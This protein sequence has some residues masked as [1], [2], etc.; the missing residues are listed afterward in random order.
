MLEGLQAADSEQWEAA[1]E[2]LCHQLKHSPP[3]SS[4]SPA[5]PYPGMIPFS[6]EDKER[7]FG[8][9]DEIEEI[10]NKVRLHPFLT[11]IGPSGSGKSSLVFAGLIPQL[12]KSGLFGAGCWCI[13]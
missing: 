8:R 10:I 13:R 5:C 12:K 9:D 1:V 2:R 6:E 3:P 4:S 7:F 11:L